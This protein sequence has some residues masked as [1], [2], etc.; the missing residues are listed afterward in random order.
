MRRPCTYQVH[1]YSL[2]IPGI[3]PVIV[4]DI[5]HLV[6][7]I[8]YDTTDG[9]TYRRTINSCYIRTRSTLHTDDF[10][11]VR[12]DAEAAMRRAIAYVEIVELK[13]QGSY[14]RPDT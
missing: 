13:S 5:G 1:A 10:G 11:I 7:G 3:F 12:D 8:R 9:A 4:P 2:I 6:P 14:N